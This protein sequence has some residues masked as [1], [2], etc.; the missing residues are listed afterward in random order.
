L[1]FDALKDQLASD[2]NWG[3]SVVM[4]PEIKIAIQYTLAVDIT[5]AD[6]KA[7]IAIAYSVM[8]D[9]VECGAGSSSGSASSS[10]STSTST[11]SPLS[12]R[13]QESKAVTIS[14][15][16]ADTAAAT[17]AAT[18][19]PDGQ[20][21]DAVV[22][23]ELTI[24]VTADAAIAPPTA[25]ELVSAVSGT[26]TADITVTAEVGD[27]DVTFTMMPCSESD[28][29]DAGGYELVANAE[30]IGCDAGTC[31]TAERDRCC[32]TLSPATAGAQGTCVLGSLS[33]MLLWHFF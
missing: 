12:R 13:L 33:S 18:L 11:S 25:D 24:T 32:R 19:S 28:I 27:V 4:V 3:D 30:T 9:A 22:T 8:E 23:V 14:F 6:C 31:T 26:A 17:T 20:V 16:A 29:C 1:D 21:G 7:E 10:A 5:D 2:G 15:A